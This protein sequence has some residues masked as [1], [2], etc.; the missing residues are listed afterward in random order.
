MRSSKRFQETLKSTCSVQIRRDSLLIFALIL[1]YLAVIFELLEAVLRA[2]WTLE[3]CPLMSSKVTLSIDLPSRNKESEYSCRRPSI[4]ARIHISKG[5][6]ISRS[7]IALPSQRP[8]YNSL[9][10]TH[11]TSL[12][13]PPPPRRSKGQKQCEIMSLLSEG[14]WTPCSLRTC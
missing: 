12:S 8:L 4:T 13:L 6:I 2:E 9:T 7:V 11:Q 14:L 1:R 10:E 3:P 5:H